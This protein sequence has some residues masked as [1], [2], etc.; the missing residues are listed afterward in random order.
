[1]IAIGELRFCDICGENL[2][3]KSYYRCE[4]CGQITCKSCFNEEGTLCDD[5]YQKMN[6]VRIIDVK[7]TNECNF[8]CGFCIQDNK[9]KGQGETISPRKIERFMMEYKNKTDEFNLVGADPTLYPYLE[10]VLD[11]SIEHNIKTSFMTKNYNIDYSLI[12]KAYTVGINIT[13]KKEIEIWSKKIKDND[14]DKVWLNVIVGYMH[15]KEFKELLKFIAESKFNGICFYNL[16][17]MQTRR[18]NDFRATML[19]FEPSMKDIHFD[20]ELIRRYPDLYEE[21]SCDLYHNEE[22]YQGICRDLINDEWKETIW[23]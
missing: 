10:K 14:I 16:K 1:M 7:I 19:K 17:G 13:T 8:Q 2:L 6:H 5:C 9:S 15:E 22:G 20:Y 21:I 23:Y 11:F 18:Y 4:K 3:R 12:E